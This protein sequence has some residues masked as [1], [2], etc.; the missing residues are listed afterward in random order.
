MAFD[1]THRRP[2]ERVYAT[3]SGNT[4]PGVVA[5]TLKRFHVEHFDTLERV[6]EACT[7]SPS[8]TFRN[9]SPRRSSHGAGALMSMRNPD[10]AKRKRIQAIAVHLQAVH[11][12]FR[13]RAIGLGS[14]P[15]FWLRG[16]RNAASALLV[17]GR[18]T[19]LAF[20]VPTLVRIDPLQQDLRS[21]YL[22]VA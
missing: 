12:G 19:A 13:Q 18:I 15:Q 21:K 22:R 1:S 20:I 9:A 5:I 10:L 2:D 14:P 17:L 16:L 7:T 11:L 8:C 3:P 6:S 4:P